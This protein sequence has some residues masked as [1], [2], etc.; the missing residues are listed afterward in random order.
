MQETAADALKIET[1]VLPDKGMVIMHLAGFLDACTYGRLEAAFAEAFAKG[2]YRL[3][4]DLA[5]V[6]YI[7]SAG[8][9]IFIGV[10]YEAHEHN[11]SIVLVNPT[12]NVQAALDLLGLTQVLQIGNDCPAALAARKS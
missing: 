9:G 7:T 4:V 5:S 11:G 10:L 12:P 8:A 3:V 1:E 2:H 6:E